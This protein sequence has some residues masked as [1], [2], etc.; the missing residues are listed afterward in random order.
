MDVILHFHHVAEEVI[1]AGVPCVRILDLEVLTEIIRMKTDFPS[2]EAER[3][4]KLKDEVEY[5]LKNLK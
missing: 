3:L 4:S 1:K 5:V 2:S